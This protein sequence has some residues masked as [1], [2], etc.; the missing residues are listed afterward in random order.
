MSACEAL[1]RR[2][3][4]AF[5]R[6]R[7]ANL[8]TPGR[9]RVRDLAT[10][11]KMDKSARNGVGVLYSWDDPDLL[12]RKGEAGGDGQLRQAAVS[13]GVTAG[14]RDLLEI[15]KAAGQGKPAR[16][17]ADSSFYGDLRRCPWRRRW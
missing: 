5:A 16:E 10:T 4:S 9:R 13:P 15:H 7:G 3:N 17:V 2:F 8:V 1:A 6:L 11:R 12:R 14:S